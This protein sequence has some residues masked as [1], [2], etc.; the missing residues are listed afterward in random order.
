MVP[1]INQNVEWNSWCYNWFNNTIWIVLLLNQPS[2]ASN[3]G[4]DG[5]L[6]QNIEIKTSEQHV[7]YTTQN[8]NTKQQSHKTRL[9]FMLGLKV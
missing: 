2:N 8:C 1:C 7:Q 3:Q 4:L 6:Q 5:S 9:T